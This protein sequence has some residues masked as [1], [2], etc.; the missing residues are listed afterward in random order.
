MIAYTR[1]GDSMRGI[2]KYFKTDTR[3][4]NLIIRG[5][6]DIH[7]GSLACEIDR[8]REDIAKIKKNGEWWF[9]G[10]DNTDAIGIKDKRFNAYNLK[11]TIQVNVHDLYR[12]Q[13]KELYEELKEIRETCLGVMMGNHELTVVDNYGVDLAGMMAELLGTTNLSYTALIN[14]SFKRNKGDAGGKIVRLFL[15]HGFGAGSSPAGAM[16]ALVNKGSTGFLADIYW[17]G[18]H[19]KKMFMFQPILT[20]LK[21]KI[22]EK[23]RLFV[24]GGTFNKTYQNGIHNYAERTAYAPAELGSNAIRITPFASKNEKDITGKSK[25]VDYVKYSVLED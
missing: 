13:V 11:A 24:L 8:L 2:T 5:L 15:S 4:S 7:Y 10:G 16:N 25:P 12:Q 1:S 19:H 9:L 3:S 18:H 21:D 6:F 22:V 17:D 14:L 20:C 23:K